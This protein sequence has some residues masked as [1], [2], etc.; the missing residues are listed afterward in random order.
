MKE[1]KENGKN[2]LI[3]LEFLC[4]IILYEYMNV[5]EKD[6]Y[7]LLMVDTVWSPNSTNNSSLLIVMSK[8]KDNSKHSISIS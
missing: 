1:K 2:L 3:N 5:T 4:P 8:A 7:L 6:I